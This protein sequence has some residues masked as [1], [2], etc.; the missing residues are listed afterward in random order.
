MKSST[1][2]SMA[3]LLVQQGVLAGQTLHSKDAFR[4][5]GTALP[6]VNF[7][8]G[9]SYAGLLP[10]SAD[11]NSSE[12]FFWYF[13]RQGAHFSEEI[14]IWL[15][16]G[17][18]CSSLK[19]F[20]QENGPISW[21][22]GTAEPV[23]NP[24]SWT[25][26][27]DVVWVEQ[28]QGTGF[29]KVK[30]TPPPPENEEEVAEQFLGFWKHF[31][32]TFELRGK[33]VY[34]AGE[35]YA[36]YYVSYIADAMY[37]QSDSKNFN[38]DGILLYDAA[39]STKTVG[40]ETPL[41]PFVEYW[42]GLFNLNRTF[43]N[44]IRQRWK[45]CKYDELLQAAFTFPPKGPILSLF[46]DEENPPKECE[47]WDD[48]YDAAT[49]VN[50]CFSE[51]HISDYCPF[52]EDVLGLFFAPKSGVYFNRTDVQKAV[53]APIGEWQ[54]CNEKVL[55]NDT[56]APVVQKVLPRVIEK[57]SRTIFANGM[58]DF[59]P[60]V[61]GSIAAIQ[62]MTWLGAQG[63]SI[64]PDQWEEFFVPH[65]D[66]G[67]AGGGIFGSWHTERKFTFVIVAQAGHMSPQYQPA[68]SYRHV[69]FLLG[70]IDSLGV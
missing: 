48:V 31:V 54:I 34:I 62:N 24:W 38:I 19:G 50:P 51:Y 59:V 37:N 3:S 41:L 15:N 68:A 25:N 65:S 60:I 17:P 70:R 11:T 32:D 9:A 53:N 69:E 22:A 20:L 55:Q 28:P 43:M 40:R 49:L 44:D 8:V 13:P 46:E 39:L 26:L 47:L 4:V 23:G 18:G 5:N 56:S 12:L 29:S 2:S 36:G 1:L 21:I 57:S 64:G 66:D 27:A 58:L 63:F 52:P 7:D 33:K 16:G 67:T 10:I 14:L 35:S 42:Q 45:K 6:E 61:N 30:A